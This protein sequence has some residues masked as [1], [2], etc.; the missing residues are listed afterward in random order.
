MTE[1]EAEV[2]SDM[3][4]DHSCRLIFT[5]FLRLVGP[6]ELITLGQSETAD[7]KQLMQI[8][9]N[10]LRSSGIGESQSIIIRLHIGKLGGSVSKRVYRVTKFISLSPHSG[11][12]LTN[13]IRY[14]CTKTIS[15]FLV[16][17]YII[18]NIQLQRSMFLLITEFSTF[19]RK[20]WHLFRLYPGLKMAVVFL[21][22]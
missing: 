10:L 22:V 18:F 3:R 11:N 15:F 5:V 6:R 8:G 1:S 12:E 16:V 2:K 9:N 4:H 14:F 17:Y 20:L 13:T 7:I 21:L 19:L